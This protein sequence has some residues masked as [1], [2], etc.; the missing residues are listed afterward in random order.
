MIERLRID[1]LGAKGDG[2][3]KAGSEP[4][5]IPFALPG[6]TVDVSRDGPRGRV[7]SILDSSS[8]RRKAPCPHFGRCGGCDLQHASE[9]LYRRFKR[10]LVVDAFRGRGVEAE[11]GELVPCA[12]ATRRRAVFSGARDGNRIVFGFFEQLSHRV[13]AIEVCLVVVPAIAA[14]L[15]DLAGLALIVADRKR[16]MRMSVT[17]TAAGLDIAL[18]DTATL[19]DGL[20]QSVLA[21][22]L[23][24]DFAR[25]ALDGEIVVEA[26]RPSIMLGTVSVSP[27][28]GSFIQAVPSAEDAMAALVVGHL[29]GAKRTT[30]L[31]CGIGTFALRLAAGSAVHAVESEADALLALETARRGAFGLKPITTERRD[32]FRRPVTA[33]ELAKFEG[34]VFDPPRAGA[35]TQARELGASKVARVAAV[36]CNPAT[37]ARDVRLL[38]DGG[39]RLRSVTPIDQFLW[40]HHV[41]AVALLER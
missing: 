28:P 34:V 29:A 9:A 11:V 1:A 33:R 31:F 38:L 21:F 35:E 36:S 19:T 30:D 22:S 17:A 32:L 16:A 40:S 12:P 26:R 8:E 18:S 27:P 13:E 5:F 20:R 39:F 10:D 6:E 23:R 15:A 24:R 37:L 41:E 7:L 2:V 25:V 3:A 4:V 14:R